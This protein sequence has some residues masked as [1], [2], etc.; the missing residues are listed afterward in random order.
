[1]ESE[2]DNG[3]SANRKTRTKL[4]MVS[5]RTGATPER[6]DCSFQPRG[7]PVGKRA[8]DRD[9]LACSL[10]SGWINDQHG[11]NRG[12]PRIAPRKQSDLVHHG[13]GETNDERLTPYLIYGMIG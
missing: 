5:N 11:S 3:K 8:L 12:K 13:A 6:V 1:M 2:S 9:R 4:N 7:V 10:C